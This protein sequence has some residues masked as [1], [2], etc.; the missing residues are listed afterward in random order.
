MSAEP[1]DEVDSAVGADQDASGGGDAAADRWVVYRPA[2]EPRWGSEARRQ[3]LFGPLASRT[4][5]RVVKFW[6][7]LERRGNAAP[8]RWLR[9]R[10]GDGDRPRLAASEQP[11]LRAQALIEGWTRPDAVAIYDDPVAQSRAFGVALDEATTR[12]LRARLDLSIE[13]FERLV[14]PTASFGALAGLPAERLIVAG[15]GT[16]TGSII[17]G[18]WPERPVIGMVS[19]AGPGRGIELLLEAG[20]LLRDRHRDLVLRLWLV[21]TS[22]AS[23]RYLAELRASVVPEPW[24]K[25][26][27]VPHAGLGAALATATVL[28]IPHPPNDY[29]DVA[30]PVKLLD[31]MASGRPVVVT[32]R[33]ETAAIIRRA[34]AGAVTAGEGAEDVAAAI[35]TILA[36]AALARRLGAAGRAIAVREFDWAVVSGRLADTLLR[37]GGPARRD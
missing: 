9:R 12:D 15:N 33:T 28:C 30:L 35:D 8:V 1:R 7:L 37:R 14:V 24:V 13:L 3:S 22:P 26:E 32:P 16:D 29:L 10:R 2:G 18:P 21:G 17:P 11:P 5:A 19:G 4:G 31:S 27:A 25:I 36:D 23:D 6:T 20:R 34:E